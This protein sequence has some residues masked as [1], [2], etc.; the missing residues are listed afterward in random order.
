[1]RKDRLNKQ[2]MASPLF[3]WVVVLIVTPLL[4]T[5]IAISTILMVNIAQ[6][7]PDFIR[8]AKDE[9]V[10]QEKYALR[11]Y[12]DLRAGLTAATTERAVR[13]LHVLT[14]Y[15]NWLLFGA[16]N[17]SDSFTA[18]TSGVEECKTYS[19]NLTECPYVQDVTC[20]PDNRYT[21]RVFYAGESHDTDV[22]GNRTETSYPSVSFSP[23]T[24]A[25][26]DS[27]SMVPG[28]EKGRL[29]GGYETTY[30]RLRSASTI[31]VTQLLHSY[32]FFGQKTVLGTFV[33]YEADGLFLGYIG[34]RQPGHVGY[35][36]W[37]SNVDNG[38]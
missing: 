37:Y 31:P 29:A 4:I 25:W 9:F 5:T 11:T 1:M 26:W 33:A 12:V 27:I 36:S 7:F 14:Q 20:D 38:A 35:S 18:L 28:E 21:Q 3:F 8:D 24:T 17:F 13:D 32:E 15:A 23:D 22:Y 16:L 6:Q 2:R 10:K 30:D 19:D 34:C